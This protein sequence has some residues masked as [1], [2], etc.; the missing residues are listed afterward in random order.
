M[1][2]YQPT[3]G[4]V[5]EY[6]ARR[7]VWI[8]ER[9]NR[10]EKLPCAEEWEKMRPR[11]YQ[12]FMAS[13]GLDNMPEKC[14]LRATEMGQFSGPG[15]KAKKLAY[16]L[17]PDCWGSAHFYRPADLP[18]DHI[19]PAILYTCGHQ[20]AGVVGYQFHAINWARRGYSCLIFDTIQQHDNP[21]DHHGL[22]RGDTPEWIAMGYTAAGGEVFN[23]IR[24]LDLLLE[25]PGID[26]ERVGV[27]GI[28]GGGSQS[29]FLA[30]ADDRL[31]A[32]ATLC[33]VSSPDFAIP[34][35]PGHCDCIY[36]RN[37]FAR[38][39]SLYAALIAPR[40]L[41]YCFARHDQLFTPEEFRALHQRSRAR[42]EKL[43]VAQNCE[44]CEYDGPHGYNHR[45]T[46]DTI[47][48]W[49][50][51][52]VAGEKHPD[53]D[54]LAIKEEDGVGDE[55]KLS[56]FHGHPPQ[57]N[58]LDLLPQLLSPRAQ[59]RLPQGKEE[60][61]T[62]K[63]SA[64]ETLSQEVF[65]LQDDVREEQN[66]EQFGAWENDD[67]FRHAW[68]GSLD[69]MQ[70]LLMQI[71]PTDGSHEAVMVGLGERGQLALP[72]AGDMWTQTRPHPISTLGIEAR[73]CGYAAFRESLRCDLNRQGCH[74]GLTPTAMLV[75]DLHHLW[76][77]IKSIANVKGRKIYLYG[78]GEGA[79][80]MLYHALMHPDPD[81]EAVILEDLP[82]SHA[83]TPFQIMRVLRFTELEHAL[84]LLAPTPVALLNPSGS[85][86]HRFFA[87]RAHER[88]G[89]KLL[90]AV[91]TA[92]A[93]EKLQNE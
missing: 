12:Q 31:K 34:N 64:L 45:E 81:V 22:N 32:V 8:A 26:H 33:G 20:A 73:G 2:Q 69:G 90:Q 87:M 46:C 4:N 70:Q 35:R 1:G 42:F 14:D 88:L 66:I 79:I 77:E 72:V 9:D 80:A 48:R 65:H 41:L 62:T 93:I 59:L 5:H 28:S 76:P 58:R 47:H 27:T 89:G 40:A 91:N 11:I 67:T 36:I 86:F 51:R 23:G 49:F 16:Q 6:Y 19:T 53:V 3:I 52:H 37:V 55:K 30:A 43:D 17:L 10:P 54:T 56:V 21:G 83:V 18:D 60:W 24:A 29:F 82:Y 74:V 39:L 15:Y 71:G 25:Q 84:G 13:L 68:R 57:P 92:Q 44:L 85:K 63:E 61:D 7:A 75:Q 78:K 38:D 50:D